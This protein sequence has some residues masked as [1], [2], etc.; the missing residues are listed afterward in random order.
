[1]DQPGRRDRG[2]ARSGALRFGADGRHH[3]EDFGQEVA[4]PGCDNG[5][6]YTDDGQ[7]RTVAFVIDVGGTAVGSASLS[8]FDPFV[9]HAEV[10]IAL[11]PEARG[12]GIGTA[13][14]RQLV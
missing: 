9:H 4:E 10:G 2:E 14:I 11:L 1:M 6:R 5:C 3:V 7:R 12:R 13:A 8:D